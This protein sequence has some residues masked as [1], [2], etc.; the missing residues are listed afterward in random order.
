MGTGVAA[1]VTEN[2]PA[3]ND[4]PV[5]FDLESLYIP[6]LT[7]STAKFLGLPLPPF[8]KIDIVPEALQ[9]NINQESGKVKHLSSED[10]CFK[11]K[12]LCI[13]CTTFSEL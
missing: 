9:G 11:L 5:L 4:L 1:K 13:M 12:R 6:P 3:N 7:S 8:L 10:F 2:G